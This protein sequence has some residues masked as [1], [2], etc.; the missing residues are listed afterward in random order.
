MIHVSVKGEQG[1]CSAPKVCV[2]QV[3]NRDD[4]LTSLSKEINRWYA[5]LNGFD[6]RFEA[7]TEGVPF[8]EAMR[9][10]FIFALKHIDD[11]DYLCYIDTDAAFSNPNRSLLE[12]VDQ[13]HEVFIGQDS[14]VVGNTI[15]TVNVAEVI[16]AYLKQT[17]QPY[18]RDF[19][20]F[21]REVK[22]QL[23]FDI[24]S[25]LGTVFSNPHGLNAGFMVFR[26]T[27]RVKAL[28]NDVLRHISL[29]GDVKHDQ[30][31]ISLLLQR[32][33]YR[34]MLKVL[35][36]DTQGNSALTMQPEFAYDEDRSFIN[37]IYGWPMNEKL[38]GLLKVRH[39][40]WWSDALVLKR[41]DPKSF[42]ILQ[43]ET[44]LGDTLVTTSFFR[45]FREQYPDCRIYYKVDTNSEY[46]VRQ[47]LD[48]FAN[49]PNVSV[50]DGEHVDMIV[51]YS[52]G[53]FFEAST[54][55][56]YVMNH[57]IYEV[58]RRE[59]GLEVRQDTYGVDVYLT[60]GEKDREA[61][62]AKFGVPDGKPICLICAGYH[63]MVNS[64]KYAGTGKLQRIVDA[65]YGEVTFVQV[66]DTGNG[67]VQNA[68]GHAVNL[69]D[70]TSVRDLLALCYHARYVITGLHSLLHIGAIGAEG[71]RDVYVLHGCRENLSWYSS[72]FRLDGVGYHIYGYRPERYGACLCGAKCC[73]RD[74][75]SQSQ[76]G[77]GLRLCGDVRDVGG[78][79]IAACL[80]DIDEAEIVKDIRGTLGHGEAGA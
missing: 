12:L 56:D 33:E 26:S 2:L 37:H 62:L 49:N 10:K 11:C 18:I 38:I 68:L 72:Y 69:I 30:D 5:V 57:S 79:A 36:P 40:R 22:G 35:P 52:C 71:R 66:G 64:I 28:L 54:Q 14:G 50:W 80:D 29:F 53:E 73:T 41:K 43:T 3:S 70:R 6:Y 42:L 16:Q 75:T 24:L 17:G 31:C 48:V 61:V 44:A 32:D 51:K 65:L 39:N 8:L 47:K 76:C 55:H 74:V 77:Q 23:Q 7:F 19:S 67:Y 4:E 78:E 1:K 13:G 60:D 25:K 27:E 58:F 9:H 15:F 34:D 63:P 46:A 21:C 59:T 45:D 20:G